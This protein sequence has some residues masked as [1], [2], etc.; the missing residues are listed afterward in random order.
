MVVGLF[1]VVHEVPVHCTIVPLSPTAQA[2]SFV[3]SFPLLVTLFTMQTAFRLVDVGLVTLLMLAVCA[4]ATERDK[5]RDNMHSV[6]A[7]FKENFIYFFHL[8]KNQL[9]AAKPCIYNF[10]TVTLYALKS[11]SITLLC[12]SDVIVREIKTL[13]FITLTREPK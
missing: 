9:L 7:N 5:Q 8:P 12:H 6:K 10:V 3:R 13:L 1:T 2:L 4:D 11:E